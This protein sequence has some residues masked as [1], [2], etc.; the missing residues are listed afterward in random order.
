MPTEPTRR[1]HRL[2]Y[3]SRIAPGAAEDLDESLRQIQM[4][5]IRSN[6]A[7]A[8]TGL[9][10]AH[11]GWFLQALE[12]PRAAVEDTFARIARDQRHRSPAVLTTEDLPARAFARWSMCASA[13]SEVDDA[14]LERLGLRESFDPLDC[15]ERWVMQLLGAIAQVHER[16]LDRQHA[17]IQALS[18]PAA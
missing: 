10:T 9:L 1:V 14:I 16:T 13:L 8:I 15:P 17:D 6:R 2:I 7:V 5:S 11:Q 12:G 3:A 4:A 18:R